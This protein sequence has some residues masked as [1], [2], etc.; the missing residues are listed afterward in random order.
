MTSKNLH[1]QQLC[2]NTGCSLEDL[3]ETL[4]DRDGWQERM[5]IM[6]NGLH[7]HISRHQRQIKK[8]PKHMII[9]E[10]LNTIVTN[11]LKMTK[12]G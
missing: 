3:P 4:D 1:I 5:M 9:T 6:I 12:S 7:V 10:L 11:F 8:I 2:T